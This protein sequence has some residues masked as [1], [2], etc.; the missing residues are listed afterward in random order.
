MSTKKPTF[1]PLAS[2]A[3]QPPAPPPGVAAPSVVAPATAPSSAP[4]AARQ[5]PSTPPEEPVLPPVGAGAQP[6]RSPTYEVLRAITLSW[7]PGFIRLAA[8][9]HVSDE[10]HGDGA[11]ARMRDS[12]TA[13]REL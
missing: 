13:L 9:D 10:T 8:G 4:G 5:E 2:A 7:G 6:K 11:V 12:G 1:D 3:I